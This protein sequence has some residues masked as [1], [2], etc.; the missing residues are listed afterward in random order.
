MNECKKRSD[1]NEELFGELHEQEE[2]GLY[3][4]KH[5]EEQ[6][7]LHNITEPLICEK[8]YCKDNCDRFKNHINGCNFCDIPK[9]K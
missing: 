8:G 3:G 5:A 7:Y 9:A 1:M 4:R 6:C 2:N